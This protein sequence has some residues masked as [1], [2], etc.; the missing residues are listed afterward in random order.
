[1]LS[2]SLQRVKVSDTD[3]QNLNVIYKEEITE[4]KSLIKHPE[5]ENW[6]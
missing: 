5:I 6:L 3:R 2:K 4:L 1:M